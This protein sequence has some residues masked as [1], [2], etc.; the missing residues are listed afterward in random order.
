MP[1]EL[2]VL[3]VS[4]A[5][6][7]SDWLFRN[8]G[9]SKGVW[10]TLAKKVGT[11]LTSLTY[12]QA[13]DKALCHGWIDGQVRKGNGDEASTSYAQRFTPRT[14]QSSWSKR[15]IE[16]VARLEKANRMT[17]AG[18]HAVSAA[19]AD[20][21]WENAYAGQ[22]TAELPPEF[23]AAVAAVPTAQ[24]TYESL[25]RQNRFAIYYRLNALKTQAGRERRI[26][27]LVDMLARGQTPYPQKK[28]VRVS[29][30]IDST[31]SSASS[32]KEM[33]SSSTNRTVPTRRSV[34]LVQRMGNSS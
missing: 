31:N 8:G 10:L 15:N 32:R 14:A 25:T 13:L 26:V 12:A 17:E 23:L 3:T 2:P 19:K 34:R 1:V 33:P 21:R 29:S 11:S 18:R 27:A 20:G 7:W 22:A 16:N 5:A 30:P 9:T 24:V 6:D 4:N 28:R